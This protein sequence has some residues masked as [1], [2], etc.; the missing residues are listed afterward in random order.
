V[1]DRTVSISRRQFVTDAAAAGVATLAF[2]RIAWAQSG[3]AMVVHK[4]P[5]CGCCAKWIDHVRAAGFAVTVHDMDDVSP[6]KA[7]HKVAPKLQSCHTAIVEGY[8]IEGHVPA[9]DVKRLLKEKPKVLGLAAPG[10]PQ[11]APGMDVTPH[12]AYEVLTFD[13]DGKTAVFAKH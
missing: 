3:P 13:A 7:K 8:V 10:M 2:R 9:E 5:T 12:Q 4:S 11:S 6:I 1:E